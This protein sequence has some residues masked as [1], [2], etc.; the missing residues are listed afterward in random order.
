M[1]VH[2]PDNEK[3]WAPALWAKAD[4]G[5]FPA[6]GAGDRHPRYQRLWFWA[7]GGAPLVGP[8]RLGQ[9]VL[10]RAGDPEREAQAWGR[11]SARLRLARALGR[12][13]L[14]V[15][16]RSRV[17]AKSVHCPLSLDW[18]AARFDL[19]VVVVLRHPLSVLASWL[20]LGL[21]DGDRHLELTGGVRR[22]YLE[23][24]ALPL[25]G[26]DPV[27]RRAW[28]AGLLTFALEASAAARGWTVVHH[29]DLAADPLAAFRG[30]FGRL[31]LNW[32]PQVEVFLRAGQAPGSGYQ[33]RRS[34]Q[35]LAAGW[36]GRLSPAQLEAA[37]FVLEGFPLRRWELSGVG[38]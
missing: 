18:L 34:P 23:P 5:R 26:V 20:E 30:L 31:G 19:D 25:P 2:E 24:W 12:P 15:L 21:A 4:L 35:Q 1:T 38:R 14:P 27:E 6:L 22:R 8:A 17:V 32:G 28:Q 33:L 16:L 37:R 13:P 9:A 3:L 29:E 11:W 7:L 36:K 10:A